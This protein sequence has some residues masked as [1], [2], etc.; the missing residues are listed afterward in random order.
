MRCLSR[1]RYCTN[2]SCPSGG[3]NLR[4][5][6][7]LTNRTSH[8][9]DY[10]TIISCKW[11]EQM[12]YLEEKF[13]DNMNKHENNEG[14]SWSQVVQNVAKMQRA[15]ECYESNLATSVIEDAKR[16]TKKYFAFWLVTLAALIGTNLG[17]LYV[18]MTM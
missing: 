10:I 5:G 6:E 17:W 4:Q 16:K 9:Q 8:L 1:S 14:L 3:P 15:L 2:E 18:F 13:I 7:Q 11:Q 12:F